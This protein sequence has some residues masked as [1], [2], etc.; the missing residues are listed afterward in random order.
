M[1]DARATCAD[2]GKDTAPCSKR[3]GCRHADGMDERL[4]DR[5]AVDRALKLQ[6]GSVL[7]REVERLRA[8]NEH[9][10]GEIAYLN[11]ADEDPRE[12]A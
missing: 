8:D 1:S 6:A 5:A 2:C 12:D 10:R 11:S 3:R 4:P 7:A 9:L